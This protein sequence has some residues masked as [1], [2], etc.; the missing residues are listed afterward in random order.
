MSRIIRKSLHSDISRLISL[1][2][3]A[4]IIMRR[5]GNI[6]Q[7]NDQYPSI[8]TFKNDIENGHSYII[9]DD[10]IPVGTFAFIPSPEITYN[11]IYNGEWLDR[12]SPYYVIHRIASS[13]NSKGIFKSI[14]DY[15]FAKTN[16][17]R[18]DTHHDNVIMR[19]L[20]IQNGFKY[21]GIIKLMNGDLRD[22]YQMILKQ[23]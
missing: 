5:S 18:I 9:E 4:R 6:H 23:P 11:I 12:H 15:C 2:N 22:A 14:I 1:T 20:L 21:C 3:E 17:I 10:G 8:S 7:W 16:N 13:L 19:H